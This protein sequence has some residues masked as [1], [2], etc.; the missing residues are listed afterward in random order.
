M[1]ELTVRS[2]DI[3]L[4]VRVEGDG[5]LIVCVHGWPELGHSWRHQ[6]AYFAA[7]GFKVAAL[8][9]RGYGRSDKPW[10]IEAYTMRTIAADV[11]AV[12]DALGGHAILFG[13][14]WGAPIVYAT[15][16]LYPDK[17]R[18]VAGLSVPFMPQTDTSFL[19]LMRHVHRG[20]FFYQLYFQD[21][22]R[23][24]VEFG[25]EPARALAKLYVGASGGGDHATIAVPQPPEAEMLAHWPLPETLPDWFGAADLAVYVEA[26]ASGGWRGPLNRYRA[27]A[28]DYAERGEL[29]GKRIAQP[30]CFIGGARDAVRYFVPGT[31]LYANA[32]GGFDDFRGATIVPKVG[33][34][35]QQEAPDAANAA[36]DAFVR[37]L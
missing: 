13:H 25:R 32:G 29:V 8:D 11:A 37:G 36:L 15:T 2:G 34:W 19:E 33:H 28:Q 35:V 27:Q 3:A 6:L 1:A 21:E 17:V 16:L 12:I 4:H 10:A 9:V 22:G 14:D 7:R 31:D 23:A 18:A 5:P 24:E 20:R 26:F 30:A